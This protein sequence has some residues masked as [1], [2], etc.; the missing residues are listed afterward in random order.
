[1]TSPYGKTDTNDRL[2]ELRLAKRPQHRYRIDRKESPDRKMERHETV[3]WVLGSAMSSLKRSVWFTRGWTLQELLAP[4]IVVFCNSSWEVIGHV[5]KS[6]KCTRNMYAYGIHLTEVISGITSIPERF[7][8][9]EQPLYGASIAQR[10][11]WASRR[12]TTR[13]EDQAYCLLGLFNVNMPMVY[14][15]GRK[16]FRRLQLEIIQRS[17]DQSIFAWTEGD[18]LVPM[19]ASSPAA[20]ARSGRIIRIIRIGAST[21]PYAIT[22]NG[23]QLRTKLYLSKSSTPHEGTRL[24]CL[25]CRDGVGSRVNIELV[26]GYDRYFRYISSPKPGERSSRP[27]LG[28]LVEEEVIYVDTGV[29]DTNTAGEL[30]R[31]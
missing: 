17:T 8:G 12:T 3:Q 7:L 25:T 11:S 24:M 5:C 2:E 14:G 22:N 30:R 21:N 16:A 27:E 23:L 18:G 4:E 15:E 9:G 6:D 19:F 29:E 28:Q 10:M 26:K 20:F 1:M 31:D 13:S